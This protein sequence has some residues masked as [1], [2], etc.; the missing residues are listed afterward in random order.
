MVANTVL[1]EL[2]I[3]VEDACFE[4]SGVVQD[5]IVAELGGEA[6]DCMLWCSL[7]WCEGKDCTTVAQ[8]VKE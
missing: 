5:L 4:R 2:T 3:P 1:V 7:S 6:T 8:K